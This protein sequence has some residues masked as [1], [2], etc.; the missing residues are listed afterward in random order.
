[1]RWLLFLSRLAFICCILFLLTLLIQANQL[2]IG[3]ELEVTFVF[4][5]Y[6]MAMLLNPAANL[7][8]LI[9]YFYQRPKL[10][11]VPRWLRFSNFAFLLLLTFY[12]F[13]LNAE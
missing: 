13:Y 8:Y 2:T 4:I 5:W 9:L 12:I 7:C 11:V 6:F 3:K 10:Q 1:M